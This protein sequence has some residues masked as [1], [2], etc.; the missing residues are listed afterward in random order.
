MGCAHS[1]PRGNRLP[2]PPSPIAPLTV[3]SGFPG[4]SIK[5][6]QRRKTFSRQMCQ[7]K[8][9]GPSERDESLGSG[10][11]IFYFQYC[12]IVDFRILEDCD[13]GRGAQ[14]MWSQADGQKTRCILIPDA[15]SSFAFPF[16]LWGKIN[17]HYLPFSNSVFLLT[18]M[19]INLFILC[20]SCCFFC[21]EFSTPAFPFSGFSIRFSWHF[22]NKFLFDGIF[23]DIDLGVIR[24]Q[25]CW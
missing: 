13:F 17:S 8:I 22:Q 4:Q 2:P 15:F 3:S 18:E 7:E 20:V 12:T 14:H 11:R 21:R 23:V 9:T 24:R 10:P 6:Q 1:P 25:I 19:H 5:R 16:W